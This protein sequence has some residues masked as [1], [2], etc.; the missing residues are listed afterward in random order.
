MLILYFSQLKC[1]VQ[2]LCMV[3]FHGNQSNLRWCY[4]GG[5]SLGGQC[6]ALRLIV[7]DTTICMGINYGETTPPR[8]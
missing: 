3:K 7:E 4:W 5:Q 6:L 8:Y 2:E 1:L